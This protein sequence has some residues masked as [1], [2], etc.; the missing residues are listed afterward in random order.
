[1][2]RNPFTATEEI[3]RKIMNDVFYTD[4]CVVYRNE[5]WM[6][7]STGV[8][9]QGWHEVGSCNGRLD[10]GLPGVAK[11]ETHKEAQNSLKFFTNTNAGIQAGDRLEIVRN[12]N[13]PKAGATFICFAGKPMYY[14]S[15]MEVT[16]DER[17]G[18]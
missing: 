1:M 18:V 3:R 14:D 15:H 12:G 5:N 10:G 9:Q 7:E 4:S 11:H 16:V 2:I 8:T 17:T 6:D 13:T